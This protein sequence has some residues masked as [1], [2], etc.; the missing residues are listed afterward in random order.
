MIN[1]YILLKYNASLHIEKVAKA[2]NK[3]IQITISNDNV[4][5]RTHLKQYTLK[6]LVLK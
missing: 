1:I 2:N 3:Y 6:H 4:K 5:I